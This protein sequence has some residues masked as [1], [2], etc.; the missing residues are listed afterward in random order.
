MVFDFVFR[1]SEQYLPF[2]MYIICFIHKNTLDLLGRLVNNVD[3]TFRE[4]FS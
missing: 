1:A 3:S 4:I 2:W